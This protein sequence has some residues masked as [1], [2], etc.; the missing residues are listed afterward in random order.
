MGRGHGAAGSIYRGGG[1]G[2]HAGVSQQKRERRHDAHLCDESR[3]YG[4]R[5]A[6]GG[7]ATVT[8]RTDDMLPQTRAAY[9]ALKVWLANQGID[10]TLADFG[11]FRTQADTTL[12]LEY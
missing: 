8:I 10:V 11:A 2:I 1:D 5:G 6:N 4:V 9:A 12:I 3:L 7:Y